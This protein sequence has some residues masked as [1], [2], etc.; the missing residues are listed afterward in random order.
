MAKTIEC[1]H[2]HEKDAG[3]PAGGKCGKCGAEYNYD[4]EIDAYALKHFRCRNLACR[5]VSDTI[6]K[7]R[8]CDKCGTAYIFDKAWYFSDGNYFPAD[9]MQYRLNKFANT[10]F[11]TAFVFLLLAIVFGVIALF[12]GTMAEFA[13]YLFGLAA[14]LAVFVF[15][16][17]LRAGFSLKKAG[18]LKTAVLSDEGK[19]IRERARAA[20]KS[21]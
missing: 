20:K 19:R 5:Q 12:S 15:I 7:H 2:C 18:G 4:K 16:G 11:G 6:T 10:W 8:V 14:V 3:I 1:V 17:L 21:K 9:S 13:I